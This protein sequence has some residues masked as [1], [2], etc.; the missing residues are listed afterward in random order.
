VQELIARIASAFKAPAV[1]VAA[2]M[3][4]LMKER[5][6]DHLFPEAAVVILAKKYNVPYSDFIPRLEKAVCGD[7]K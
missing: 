5:F 1:Q 6:D 2:E 3:N 7:R 4:Q